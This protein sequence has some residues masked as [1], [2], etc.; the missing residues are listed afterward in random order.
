MHFERARTRPNA[1]KPVASFLYGEPALAKKPNIKSYSK[2]ELDQMAAR[3]EDRTDW[4]QVRTLTESELERAIADD[5]DSDPPVDMS[6]MTLTFR[7]NK[8]G[9]FLRLDPEVLD[10]FKSQCPR[11]QTR[12]NAV[13]RA[14]VEQM[15]KRTISSAGK[16]AA[17]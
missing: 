17:E 6:M 13:L 8:K 16:T 14:Y 5:P 10:F 15:S 2:T 7:A 9:V 12:I 3:G 1:E 11:Y 4:T